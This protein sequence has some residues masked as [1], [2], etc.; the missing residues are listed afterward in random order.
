MTPCSSRP[1]KKQRD[2]RLLLSARAVSETGAEVSRLAIPLTAA[3]L[4]GASPS[5]WASSPP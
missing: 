3:I 4:L 2:Y 1:P 5:R